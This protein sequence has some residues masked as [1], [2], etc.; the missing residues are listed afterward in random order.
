VEAFP[1]CCAIVLYTIEQSIARQ[2]GV[3]ASSTIARYLFHRF[4]LEAILAPSAVGLA[5]VRL[6]P[7]Q[8]RALSTLHQ[9]LDKA[10]SPE[11]VFTRSDPRERHLT[12]LNSMIPIVRNKLSAFLQTVLSMGAPYAPVMEAAASNG[13]VTFMQADMDVVSNFLRNQYVQVYSAI[14]DMRGDGVAAE[15]S[16]RI[17]PVL[18]GGSNKGPNLPLGAVPPKPHPLGLTTTG[19]LSRNFS[20]Y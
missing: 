3:M 4:I 6:R 8:L 17:R 5:D 20:L 10:A 13:G 14:V 2:F 7:D 1:H 16:G 18:F 11:G 15:C 9:V 12:P 19:A